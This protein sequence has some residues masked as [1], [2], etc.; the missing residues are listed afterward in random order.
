MAHEVGWGRYTADSDDTPDNQDTIKALEA[1]LRLAKSGQIRSLM[2]FLAYHDD[3]H[4]F[5]IADLRGAD[6]PPFCLLMGE[7]SDNLR[8]QWVGNNVDSASELP[9]S[10]AA[11]VPLFTPEDDDR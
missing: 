10:L 1:A 9:A 5:R 8:G 2:M 7:L 11:V 6:V 4:A 3:R